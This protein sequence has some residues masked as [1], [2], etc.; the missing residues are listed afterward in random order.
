MISNARH[1]KAS[2]AR[3]QLCKS[4]APVH[5]LLP[6]QPTPVKKAPSC[7]KADCLMD[8]PMSAFLR[9]STRRP[10]MSATV[11]GY[12]KRARGPRRHRFRTDVTS[13]SP[14]SW[15]TCCGAGNGYVLSRCDK[16]ARRNLPRDAGNLRRPY[17]SARGTRLSRPARSGE[18]ARGTKESGLDLG[19]RASRRQFCDAGGTPAVPGLS[20]QRAHSPVVGGL[21][22]VERVVPNA[23]FD[24]QLPRAH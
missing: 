1:R 8:A 2:S 23:L 21:C 5:A 20:N 17:S 3:S 10:A 18:G 24:F 11:S 7:A 12:R 16:Q 9:A 6:P 19:P 15:A 22:K 4:V 14:V 13:T